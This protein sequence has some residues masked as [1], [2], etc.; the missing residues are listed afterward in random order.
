M[1]DVKE[2]EGTYQ[3]FVSSLFGLVT[4]QVFSTI[5]TKVECETGHDLTPALLRLNQML[6]RHK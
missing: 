6:Q 2:S 1:E 3:C 5:K 4:E